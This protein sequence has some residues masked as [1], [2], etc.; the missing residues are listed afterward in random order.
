[1]PINESIGEDAANAR[2]TL[3]RPLPA[4]AEWELRSVG[5]GP[6]QSASLV[7]LCDALLPKLLNGELSV[8]NLEKE[9]SV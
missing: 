9:A 5:H 4:G 3:T 1:M 6:H 8:A 7:L 2:G